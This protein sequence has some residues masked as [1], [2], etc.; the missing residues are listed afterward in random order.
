VGA[1]RHGAVQ[2][3]LQFAHIAREV[4]AR[5]TGTGLGRQLGRRPDPRIAR[6]ALEQGLADV[7]QILQALAQRRHRD[8]MTL[9]R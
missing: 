1:Q 7:V 5:Q 3:V 6:D 8:A 4:V 9:R 2:Q